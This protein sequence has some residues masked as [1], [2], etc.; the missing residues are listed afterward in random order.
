MSAGWESG[1]GGSIVAR[2]EWKGLTRMPG[3]LE[4]WVEKHTQEATESPPGSVRRSPR[5]QRMAAQHVPGAFVDD[6]EDG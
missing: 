1:R 5:L 3:G 6:D 2:H 4:D